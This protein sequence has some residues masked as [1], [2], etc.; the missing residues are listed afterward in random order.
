MKKVFWRKV[1]IYKTQKGGTPNL[2][3]EVKID[4]RFQLVTYF[5]VSTEISLVYGL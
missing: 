4:K 3:Q 2:A 1:N 5:F